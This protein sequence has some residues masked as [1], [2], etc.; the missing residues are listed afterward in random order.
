VLIVGAGPAGTRAAETL[1]AHGVSPIVVDEGAR[2][3][4]QIYR[5]PPEGFTRPAS[6]LYGF[7]APKAEAVHATFAA[8]RDRIDHRPNTLI[9]SIEENVAHTLG[10]DGIG[11]IAFDALVL[12]TGAMDRV[13]PFPGWTLPG[14]FTMG[15]SQV[16]LKAQGCA[17]GEPV[18][19]MGTGPLLY[20][21]AYQYA[22]AGA[23]VAAVLDTS[24][25]GDALRALP[26]LLRGG[27]TLAKGIWYM[28]WPRLNGIPVRRGITPVAAEGTTRLEALRYRDRGGRE[29]RVACTGLGFGY[30]VKSEVQLAELAGCEMAFDD[31]AQQWLP[32]ADED[33][34]ARRGTLYLA[35][36]GAGVMGA[37]AAELRG[38]LAALALVADHNIA[39]SDA[40]RAGYRNRLRR[41]LRFRD[42]LERALP[43]PFHLAR[44]LPDETVICRCE[45]ITAGEIRQGQSL[46][47]AELNRAKA[48]T[49]IGMGRCQG[50]VCGIAAAQILAAA[51]NCDVSEVGR[52]RGQ[53][54][55]K[56]LD[57]TIGAR[58]AIEGRSR[59][60]SI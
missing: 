20:L 23:T 35:G 59:A 49:R 9:W 2:N 50:R 8:M 1:V 21:V 48:F 41:I 6:A 16:A 31:V 51:R 53:A 10:P 37:D 60:A 13:I 38:R 46:A 45:V 5:Q 54:P 57:I 24:H 14:V 12:A 56:P 30:G 33:G 25:A 40:A 39:V 43:P 18:V 58:G 44:T 27:R 28:T 34:R 17:I 19:F 42:G 32:V 7:E 29:H 3:G 36:D 15:G 55:V 26:K 47:P 22:H 52:L 11:R 4:G